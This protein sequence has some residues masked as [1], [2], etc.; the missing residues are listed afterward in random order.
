MHE[1]NDLFND[2][3]RSFHDP[4]PMFILSIIIWQIYTRMLIVD[5][6]NLMVYNI[7]NRLQTL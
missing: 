4:I 2:K 7:T 5:L 1:S 6:K 3:Q